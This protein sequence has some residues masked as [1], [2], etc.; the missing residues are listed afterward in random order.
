MG[1]SLFT[2]PPYIAVIQ[3]FLIPR[4][5]SSHP[6]ATIHKMYFNSFVQCLTLNGVYLSLKVVFTVS[7][8]RVH[9]IFFLLFLAFDHCFG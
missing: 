7:A 6:N 1:V 3:N 5:Q 8:L 4:A 9:H 2:V